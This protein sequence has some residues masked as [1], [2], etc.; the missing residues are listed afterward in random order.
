MN[1]CRGVEKAC[2]KKILFFLIMAGGLTMQSCHRKSVPSK[3]EEVKAMEEAKTIEEA[4]AAEIAVK[5]EKTYKAPIK[6][7]APKMIVV[8][9]KAAKKT[10]DGRY[11]YDLERKR[12]WR[13]KADGKYYLYYKGMFDNK[14]FK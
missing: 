10:L 6:T 3:S 8:N 14:D 12:Y 1:N 7:V 4:K 11:Y 2:M 5:A 13:S 9:D